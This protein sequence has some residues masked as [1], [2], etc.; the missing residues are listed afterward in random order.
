M[1]AVRVENVG[2]SGPPSKVSKQEAFDNARLV[3]WRREVDVGECDGRPKSGECVPIRKAASE[4]D[5][6]A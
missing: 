3:E 5:G 6:G 1:G 2:L 4:G